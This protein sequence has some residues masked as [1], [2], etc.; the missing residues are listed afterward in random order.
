MIY[1]ARTPAPQR[2]AWY[3][4]MFPTVEGNSTFYALPPLSTLDHWCDSTPSGF[5]FC[6]KFPQAISHTAQLAVDQQTMQPWLRWIEQTARKD[7]LGPSLLQLGPAF[8]SCSWSTLETFLKQ[9]PK[10]FPWA[11]ELRHPDWFDGENWEP[12]VDQ[13]LLEQGIDRVHL[14]ATWLF[15]RPPE[16]EGERIASA[17]KPKVAVRH[18]TPGQRPMLR[19]IGRDHAEGLEDAWGTWAHTICTWMLDGKQPWI[20]THAP[21]D[22]QA[23]FLARRLFRLIESQL[24]VLTNQTTTGHLMDRLGHLPATSQP[25]PN[26]VRQPSLFD[27]WETSPSSP[28]GGEESG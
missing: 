22:R 1:P 26:R 24:R 14:D 4:Q 11:V 17:K 5:R 2:L 13:L 23:P 16:T 15:S 28:D 25:T 6:F 18:R 19:L 20:F 8:S 21:D 27:R 3:S 7:R 9:L 10:E 12:R